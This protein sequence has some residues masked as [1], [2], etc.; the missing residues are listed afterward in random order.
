MIFDRKQ[1]SQAPQALIREAFRLVWTRENWPAAGMG[2]K[3]WERLA[4]VAL[5]KIRAAVTNLSRLRKTIGKTE[6]PQPVPAS[7][8]YDLW[9]GPAPKAPLRRKALHY[10]WHWVWSTGTG[11]TACSRRGR[12]TCMTLPG[13]A[14]WS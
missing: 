1:L 4:A 14:T 3:E 8:D 9:C 11:D 7:V 6:G 2:F 12:G 5:G 13:P 10:E